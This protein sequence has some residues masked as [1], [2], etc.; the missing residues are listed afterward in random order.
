MDTADYLY[1]T[2]KIF[3]DKHKAFSI[4]QFFY[5]HLLP[6]WWMFEHRDRRFCVLF[7]DQDILLQKGKIVWGY[8]VQ[9]NNLLFQP[10]KWEHP[11]V[12]VYS[13][14]PT[15]HNNLSLLSRIAR[16][17]YEL[18]DKNLEHPEM[19]DLRK[20]GEII[21]NE[22][23]CP[24]NVVVPNIITMNRLVY[25]TSILVYRKHLPNGYLK[26][27]WFPILVAPDNTPAAMILPAR[28][29]FSSLIEAWCDY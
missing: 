25:F 8:L 13:P 1:E 7:R 22:M 5:D 6:P 20:F 29:W 2:R 17:L 26:S 27:G 12:I 24:F 19:S 3:K 16:G 4:E 14:E 10:G 11:A 9:A 15:F 18:K 28:Y 21:T 23:D